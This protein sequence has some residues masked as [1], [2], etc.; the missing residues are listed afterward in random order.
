MRWRISI[1]TLRIGGSAADWPLGCCSGAMDVRLDLDMFGFGGVAAAIVDRGAL[2]RSMN[3]KAV[4]LD[5]DGDQQTC[6]LQ[7]R[8]RN[9][10]SCRRMTKMEM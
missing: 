8:V 7:R 4:A 2:R 5:R 1:G 10:E 9:V 3:T 6:R